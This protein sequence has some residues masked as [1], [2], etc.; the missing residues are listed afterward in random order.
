M[1][2]QFSYGQLF[3]F[4]KNIFLQIGCSD[5][6]AGLAAKAL[7][8]ADLRGVDSH[9]I[10][11][12][13]GYVRL[14]QAKRVNANPQI[15]IVHETLSTAVVDGDKGLGLVVGPAAMRVGKCK[16]QQP[17]WY[18]RLPCHDGFTT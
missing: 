3:T 8:A 2:Q 12:L 17:F 13:S 6:H 9:G 18:C 11:R 4:T 5:A 15:K 1:H 16:E 10:A 7:L 14:W